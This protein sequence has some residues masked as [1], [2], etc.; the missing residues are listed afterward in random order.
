MHSSVQSAIQ[1]I[2]IGAGD[3]QCVLLTILRDRFVE[4]EA[5]GA[6]TITMTMRC[7]S[8]DSAGKRNETAVPRGFNI[9]G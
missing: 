4:I 9:Q 7:S 3:G 1:M 2:G 5:A 8:E 6:I